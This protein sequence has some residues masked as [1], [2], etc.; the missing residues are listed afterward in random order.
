[1][2]ALLAVRPDPNLP[3][4]IE[5]VDTAPLASGNVTIAVSH[6]A[7]N[8][9]DALAICNRAPILRSFP[10]VPGIDLAGVVHASDDPRWS[11]GQA[12]V[13]AGRGIGER[14]S[15]GYSRM[16][17]Q[18][19]DILTALPTS[20]TPH[21]AM[22]IGTA[23]ITAAMCV[24]A[25]IRHGIRPSD[26]PVLVTGATGGVGM[27]A[28]AMLSQRGYP[29]TAVTGRPVYTDDLLRCGATMVIG[30]E[31][32]AGDKPLERERWAAVVE[33]VAG[34]VANAAIRSTA[35]GGVV[36]MCGNASGADLNITVYPLI[37]R[38]ISIIGI[39]S[40]NGPQSAV[41]TA[42]QQAAASWNSARM[43]HMVRSV[44]LA[45][46]PQACREL[47]DGQ[48]IGRCVVTLS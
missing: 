42:W 8:Y 25:I 38:G 1:M 30:R 40:V 37:L 2:P 41:D 46:V 11:V 23:G 32:I 15:G 36:A 47:L 22:A 35:Y 10:M 21:D 45:D 17:C 3:P 27:H 9:K 5:Y 43:A 18:P 16:S 19:G 48:R 6:S 7:I 14:R 34:N 20:L 4:Q 12:V 13:I 31:D 28:V 39:D 44:A 33:T 29:V 26:R 24:E